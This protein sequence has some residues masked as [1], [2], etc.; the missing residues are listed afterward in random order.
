MPVSA[1]PLQAWL[2]AVAPGAGSRRSALGLCSAIGAATG[3]RERALSGVA[4]LL[5]SVL[6][7]GC[8]RALSASATL[9]RSRCPLLLVDRAVRRKAVC[10][11]SAANADDENEDKGEREGRQD[12]DP[13][14][15]P[16]AM[17]AAILMTSVGI[18]LP[19]FS[20]ISP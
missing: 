15:A 18:I 12:R 9:L 6:Y 17:T 4:Q 20:E 19:P 14:T 7:L 3:T 1:W 13:L 2:L 16:T 8:R 10:L 11:R 5:Q